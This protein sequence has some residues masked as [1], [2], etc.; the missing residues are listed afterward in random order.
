MQRVYVS[1]SVALKMSNVAL[2]LARTRVKQSSHV[3]K[4]P[5]NPVVPRESSVA[6]TLSQLSVMESSS[7]ASKD[8]VSHLAFELPIL[9]GVSV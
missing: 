2:T 4:R 5:V 3:L 7:V 8:A 6:L 9:R 1:L